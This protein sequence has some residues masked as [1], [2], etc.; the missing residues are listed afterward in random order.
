MH[1][2]AMLERP[3]LILSLAAVNYF[4][5][6]LGRAD[7]RTARYAE[8][9]G[10]LRDLSAVCAANQSEVAEAPVFEQAR[11]SLMEHGLGHPAAIID[12]F[13]HAA[14]TSQAFEA[15]LQKYGYAPE[16]IRLLDAHAASE[17]VPS[18]PPRFSWYPK[19]Y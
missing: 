2:Y 19:K 3:T 14:R 17:D 4:E 1:V 11:F 7:D 5:H 8:L 13:L 16:D 10:V 18:G 6:Q 12:D 15:V 9:L